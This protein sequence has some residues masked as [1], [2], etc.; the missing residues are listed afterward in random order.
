VSKWEGLTRMEF[1]VGSKKD[2]LAHLSERLDRKQQP[3]T[4][5]KDHLYGPLSEQI[6]YS[7][8]K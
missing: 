4:S 7:F 2:P 5:L 3:L 6:V 8:T 1:L